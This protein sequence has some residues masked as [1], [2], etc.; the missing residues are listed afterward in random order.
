MADA[1][2]F[3]HQMQR[4]PQ[5]SSRVALILEQLREKILSYDKYKSYFLAL[6]ENDVQRVKAML[7]Q[8]SSLE[9][10]AMLNGMFDYGEDSFIPSLTLAR[11]S[12]PLLIA[13]VF[14]SFEVFET[15][16]SEGADLFQENISQGNILHSMLASCSLDFANQENCVVFYKK[17]VALLNVDHMQKLLLHENAEGMRPLEYA[18]HLGCMLLFECIQLTPGVYVTKTI[19]KGVFKEEWIDVTEYESYEPGNRRHLSP[20]LL[21]TFIDRKAAMNTKVDIVLGNGLLS[22]WLDK[23][24]SSA[25]WVIVIMFISRMLYAVLF[26]IF[27]TKGKS[28]EAP[29]PVSANVP[30]PVLN[31]TCENKFLYFDTGSEFSLTIGVYL[32]LHSLLSFLGSLLSSIEYWKTNMKRFKLKLGLKKDCILDN[33]FYIYNH[34][35]SN[36][37]YVLAGILT[38]VGVPDTNSLLNCLVILTCMTSVW[39]IIFFIQILPSTGYFVIA[40]QRMIWV[41]FQFGVVFLLSFLPFPHAFYRLLQDHNGCPNIIFSPSVPVTYYN[42]FLVLINMFDFTQFIT[43]LRTPDYF[44]LLCLHVL[45]V[46]FLSILLIN[47]L[48]ALLSTSVAEIMDSK[49]VVIAV[50]RMSVLSQV[51]SYMGVTRCLNP[52]WRRMQAGQ[53]HVEHDRLYL[54]RVSLVGK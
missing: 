21:F 16:I 47:F 49:S 26:Y 51:E 9:R 2:E 54:I 37:T 19:D 11:L 43:V 52:L 31:G 4:L 36:L 28:P 50:Q 30:A 38:L 3:F 48:I 6:K 53:F 32:I 13:V 40:M 12:R 23:K 46:F 45:Y 25:K 7:S 44:M 10:E 14:N 8:A 5:K 20:L 33:S 18:V 42:S 15:M 27:I 17:L 34:L 35:V 24:I 39:S 41:M 1:I 29:L 22:L